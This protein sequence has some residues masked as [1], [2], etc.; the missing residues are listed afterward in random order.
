MRRQKRSEVKKKKKIK[1]KK[2]SQEKKVFR[3]NRF[4]N[5]ERQDERAPRPMLI[6]TYDNGRKKAE[7][8]KKE[9][10]NGRERKHSK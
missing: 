2:R 3:L 1:N 4:G 8:E 5:D 7:R 6:E 9:G 10:E